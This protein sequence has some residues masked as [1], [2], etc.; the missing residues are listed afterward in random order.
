LGPHPW[1]KRPMGQ[2]GARP[3]GAVF[4]Q[5][6]RI[7]RR[8]RNAEQFRLLLVCR[9]QQIEIGIENRE[10]AEQLGGQLLQDPRSSRQDYSWVVLTE[11]DQGPG[12]K[13][14]DIGA[15]H[16]CRRMTRQQR[17]TTP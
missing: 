13:A 10:A 2:A 7:N 14:I 1:A 8:R 15:F 6:C 16:T 3:R 5:R 17:C 11:N 9:S 4:R 12:Y